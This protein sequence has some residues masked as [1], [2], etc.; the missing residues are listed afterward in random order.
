MAFQAV[1]EEQI[2]RARCRVCPSPLS[3]RYEVASATRSSS[4]CTA[5]LS[6]E[7]RPCLTVALDILYLNFERL[8]Y[9]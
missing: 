3:L 9:L 4:S 5:K 1:S 6:P 7:A 2:C 8:R